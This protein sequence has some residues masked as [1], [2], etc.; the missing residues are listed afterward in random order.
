M[1]MAGACRS[2]RLR[3]PREGDFFKQQSRMAPT[4]RRDNGEFSRMTREAIL[5]PVQGLPTIRGLVGAR[6]GFPNGAVPQERDRRFESGSLQRGVD[7]E[8]ARAGGGSDARISIS[9]MVRASAP[10]SATGRSCGRTQPGL[11]GDA[12]RLCRF[13]RSGGARAVLPQHARHGSQHLQP[14]T[15]PQLPMHIADLPS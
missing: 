11:R 15:P 12:G 2:F 4:A 14:A 9:S 1:A 5:G 10:I 7:R 13:R 6:V 8:L 3:P